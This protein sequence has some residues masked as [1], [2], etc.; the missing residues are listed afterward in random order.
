VAHSAEVTLLG[1]GSAEVRTTGGDPYVLCERVA[2]EIDWK[3]ASVFAFE[4]RC[5]EPLEF[6]EIFFGDPFASHNRYGSGPLP[7]APEWTAFAADL[8]AVPGSD[9]GPA[10]RAFRIDFGDRAGRTI[11]VRGI[12]L[13]AQTAAEHQA[14]QQRQAAETAALKALQER[15]N[16]TLIAPSRMPPFDSV[17]GATHGLQDAGG[18]VQVSVVGRDLDLVTQVASHAGSIQAPVP[19]P[20]PLVVGEGASPRNHTLVRVLN[21]YGLCEGQFLAYPESVR[22]GVAVAAGRRADGQPAVVTAPLA[23]RTVRDL[24]VVGRYGNPVATITVAAEMAPPFAIAVGGFLPALAGDEVAIASRESATGPIVVRFYG[25]GG[26]FLKRVEM[27]GPHIEG[28]ALYLSTASRPGAADLLLAHQ[29][30]AKAFLSLDADRGTTEVH[31]VGLPAECTGVYASAHAGRP[32]AAAC[33]EPLHSALYRPGPAGPPERVDVGTRENR[34]W[35][36]PGGPF[37]TAP[38]GRYVR[39]SGFAHIRTDFA[40][41]MART[42]DFARTDAEFWTGERYAAWVADRLKAFDKDLPTCWEPC[43]THRWFYAQARTWAEARDAET[44]LPGYTLVTRDNET[45][46]YG[47]FGE[48]RSFVSGTYAP[49][50]PPIECFYTYPL[51]GFLHELVKRVRASPEH[52]VAVEPNHEMEINAESEATHGDYNPN[53]IRAF[54]RYL[55]GLYGSLANINRLFATD[56]SAS[57]FDAPRDLQRGPW[58]SYSTGNPYYMVWMR[59]LND[60]IYRVVAGTYREALL[61]GFPPEAVK[62]HQIPDHYAIASLAAFSRPAQRI[63][64]IDWNLNAGVGFGCTKYGVWYDQPHNCVQGPNSSGFDAMVIGEYQSL[65]PDA[66]AAYQQLVYLQGHGVQFIHC[67]DWPAGHDRG[68]NQSLAAALARLAQADVPR[69]GQTGGTGE[70]RAVHQGDRAYDIVSLGGRTE[71][72]GLLK[73]VAADGTWEGSVYV[74]P[75]HAHVEIETLLSKPARELGAEA[76]RVGPFPGIDAGNLVECTF[77]A[78]SAGPAAGSVSLKVYHHGIEMPA[79]SLVSAVGPEWRNLRLLVRVQMDTDDLAIELGSGDARQ[80][81]WGQ[82][83]LLLRDLTLVRHTEKTTKLKKGI[84]AGVRHEGG[85]TFDV[86]PEV[87]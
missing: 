22:G 14:A 54:Y 66:E 77:A 50:V 78:K 30:S 26:D 58:D 23:N 55:V 32:F 42:P 1:D 44:G 39:H 4:Y 13:R 20:P 43:F 69:P 73:S 74:V 11:Q 45:G 82:G 59:S 15:V 9:W 8:A 84:F 7:P 49:G 46:T 37:S 52:F 60:V 62:C 48:T 81:T 75:F 80:G 10:V 53:M 25:L 31:D 29:E 79:Q 61:A 18:T 6:F 76:I 16:G 28:K 67:M 72:T 68:Y 70:V 47:E 63:T 87:P 85:V 19:M 36:T 33:R 40:S 5:P 51:R 27:S 21:R 86:L 65:T 38:E 24:R 83:S 2:Q 17:I 56:F 12:H 64:P 35:F 71:S 41:P 34:F 3:E 57:R